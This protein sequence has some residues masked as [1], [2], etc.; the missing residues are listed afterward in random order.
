MK[1][2]YVKN[3]YC[4]KCI[5]CEIVEFKIPFWKDLWCQ[6]EPT[7]SKFHN[8]CTFC[9]LIVFPFSAGVAESRW[10]LAFSQVAPYGLTSHCQAVEA[11]ACHKGPDSIFITFSQCFTFVWPGDMW[12][13]LSQLQRHA[14]P[15][16]FSR[17][18]PF[19]LHS[20]CCYSANS[21]KTKPNVNI[22][23]NPAHSACVCRYFTA[24]LSRIFYWK[25][26]AAL[27]EALLVTQQGPVGGAILP[28]TSQPVRK[29]KNIK[30]KKI[31]K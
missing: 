15:N 24:T 13:F 22:I 18:P 21:N 31:N 3:Q 26:A 29:K 16:V 14:N 28:S 8:H 5:Q 7:L 17:P 27:R 9:N 2:T 1:L 30:K 6:A 25:V 10:L 4:L 23:F 20:T 11:I 19:R 12:L